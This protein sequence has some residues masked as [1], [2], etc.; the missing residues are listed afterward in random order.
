[1]STLFVGTVAFDSIKTPFGEASRVLGGSA[2]FASLAASFFIKKS[3]LLSVVGG[4]FPKTHISL[5]KE[6]NISLQ[7]LVVKEREKTFF[8]SGRYHNNMNRRDT[9]ETQLNVL[10]SFKPILPSSYLDCSVLVLANLDPKI[11]S[12]V[13][14][15]L[16]K[17]PRLV[18]L[19]TMNFWLDNSL[20][21]LL[22]NLHFVDV[23]TIN[24]EEVL[25]L[26]KKKNL[27]DAV[28]KVLSLGPSFLVVKRGGD[29]ALLFNKKLNRFSVP[30]FPVKRV[31]DPT[32]AGDSFAGGFVG[33][34]SS[35]E[36]LSFE[37]MKKAL[38][39]G[40]VMGSFCVEGFGVEGLLSVCPKDI[41]G[42][43]SFLSKS[44]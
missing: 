6:K 2:T 38:L 19:D 13:F 20:S 7:G 41:S 1:M 24:E 23:L 10:A 27:D 31:L 37:N 5:L 40:S 14:F 43:Y 34:L 33:F 35:V 9:L 15:Q 17:R 30:A 39:F 21:F 8:W 3:N 18:I 36:S 25:Q 32:G 29:G 28:K 4:D 12:S 11:Q 16:K 42:R 22:K 44:I 26:S